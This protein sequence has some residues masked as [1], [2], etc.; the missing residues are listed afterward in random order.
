[1]STM[2]GTDGIAARLQALVGQDGGERVAEAALQ[3]ARSEYPALAVERYLA[4]IDAIA[5]AIA[6]LAPLQAPLQHRIERLNRHLFEDLGFEGNGED[7]HNPRNSYLNDVLDR[8]RGIPI[9]LAV[10][11]MEVG[12]RLS[13]PVSGVSFPGHFLVR[14]DD[15]ACALVLDP[16]HGGIELDEPQLRERLARVY[17][18]RAFETDL[19]LEPLLRPAGT[20]EILVR[21]LRN[22]KGVYAHHGQWSRSLEWVNLIIALEPDAAQEYRDRGIILEKLECHSAAAVDYEAYLRARPDAEDADQVRE[23]LRQARGRA[24]RP[25]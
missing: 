8:K 20:R 22:L 24:P 13:I 9:T 5:D 4:R 12:R 15:P 1:M 18:E 25:N 2:S 6:P 11:Y 21:M 3:I 19:A 23:H 16:F 17:G 14:V 7:Y 10:I